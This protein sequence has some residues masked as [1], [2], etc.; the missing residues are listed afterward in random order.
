MHEKMAFINQ[1]SH[2]ST[3]LLIAPFPFQI[4]CF[5]FVICLICSLEFSAFVSSTIL[6][7]YVFKF[8]IEAV[9]TEIQIY[10]ENRLN[11]SFRDSESAHHVPL[12]IDTLQSSFSCCGARSWMDW[13]YRFANMT[14]ST[15]AS[16]PTGPG[17][18][19]LP[20]SCCRKS[21]NCQ[22][23]VSIDAPLSSS[24]FAQPCLPLV[25]NVLDRDSFTYG[26]VC[27]SIFVFQVCSLLLTCLLNRRGND[28]SIYSM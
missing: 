3:M 7:D 18:F 28:R 17:E 22:R 20:F 5:G 12:W 10:P 24:I 19:I 2:I 14:V 8:S 27:I 21:Q 13:Q 4:I 11:A 1:K 6:R 9:E 15:N 23:N 26:L 25:R 16:S